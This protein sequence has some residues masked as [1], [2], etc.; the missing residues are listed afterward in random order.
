MSL[1]SHQPFL[2][3]KNRRE[4]LRDRR[5]NKRLFDTFQMKGQGRAL[6]AMRQGSLPLASAC[7]ADLCG[8]GGSSQELG[9][10]RGMFRGTESR[11]IGVRTR[12]ASCTRGSGGSAPWLHALPLCTE[13]SRTSSVPTSHKFGSPQCTSN[14]EYL[15]WA[16]WAPQHPGSKPQLEAGNLAPP[17]GSGLPAIRL[18]PGSSQFRE[19]AL[20]R[21][22]G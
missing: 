3:N 22:G 18:P 10:S 6:R 20:D 8:P 19:G 13:L 12:R 14:G 1:Q 16:T 17:I 15:S 11:L 21:R 7:R 2:K 5:R 4:I 9:V